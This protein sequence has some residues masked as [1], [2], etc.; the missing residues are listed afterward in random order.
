M[1]TGSIAVIAVAR[2]DGAQSI[3]V[4]PVRDVA[5]WRVAVNHL[6]G[7]RTSIED[8]Q[9]VVYPAGTD[10]ASAI[11]SDFG[12]GWFNRV[13]G[14][15]AKLAAEAE[16]VAAAEFDRARAF[17]KAGNLTECAKILAA[18]MSPADGD[19]AEMAQTLA[20]LESA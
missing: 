20:Y 5:A 2:K 12:L 19:P 18:V 8:W 9:S 16:K 1:K 7:G 6:Y 15:V 4:R 3:R 10:L 14:E 13:R 11:I 17:A